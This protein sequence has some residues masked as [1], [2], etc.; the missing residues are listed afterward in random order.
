M[1]NKSP[2]RAARL[3][4]RCVTRVEFFV[5]ALNEVEHCRL[6]RGSIKSS[7]APSSEQVL[8]AGSRR[9][10]DESRFEADD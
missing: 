4:R 7:P 5:K 9:G 8:G 2:S 1:I 3:A 6:E 10:F